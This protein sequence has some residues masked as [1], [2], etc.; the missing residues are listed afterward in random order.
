MRWLWSQVGFTPS[1]FEFDDV[2]KMDDIQQAEKDTMLENNGFMTGIKSQEPTER[3]IDRSDGITIK[4][5]PLTV[6]DKDICDFLFGHGLP[7]DHDI[8]NIRINRGDRKTCV[9][10]EGLNPPEVRD[11]L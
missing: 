4:N 2:D 8:E 6:D 11:L 9:L 5:I 7:E 10:I 1:S 3:D